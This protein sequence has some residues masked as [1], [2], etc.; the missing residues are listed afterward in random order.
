M[1][2]TLNERNKISDTAENTQVR[3]SAAR[4]GNE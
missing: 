3:L 1:L 4:K 2:T